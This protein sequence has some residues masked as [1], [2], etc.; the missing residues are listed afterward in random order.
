MIHRLPGILNQT[1]STTPGG[2]WRSLQEGWTFSGYPLMSLWS[3]AA[4]ATVLMLVIIGLWAWRTY[5]VRPLRSKPMLIFHQ[6]A[7][8]AR[9]APKDEW[10]LIL[11]ARHQALPTPLTLLLSPGTFNHHAHR[12]LEAVPEK[13]RLRLTIQVDRLGRFLFQ[14]DA[15]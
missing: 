4:V 11:I 15:R 2:G 8:E 12:Y 7:R 13:R 6:I 10:L 9:V 14:D 1:R 5:Y 3:L